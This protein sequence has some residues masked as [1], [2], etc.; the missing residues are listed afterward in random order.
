MGSFLL[1]WFRMVMRSVT[2]M[3]THW[4]PALALPW[5]LWMTMPVRPPMLDASVCASRTH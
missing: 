5:R 1:A 3:V 4:S 2:V